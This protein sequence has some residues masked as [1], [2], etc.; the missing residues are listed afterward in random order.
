MNRFEQIRECL[1]E[2]PTT[3]PEVAASTGMSQKHACARLLQLETRGEV[4]RIGRIGH[5]VLFEATARLR[6]A[7]AQL[8]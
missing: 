7:G 5:Q 8:H 1:R 3:S 6:P 4:R 2:G